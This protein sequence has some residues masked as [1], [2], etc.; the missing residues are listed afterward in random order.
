MKIRS[1]QTPLQN[2][3][4]N[5]LT[6]P[7]SALLTL[8]A[9]SLLSGCTAYNESFDCPAGKGIGCQSVTEVKKKLDQGGIN[10][11]ESTTQAYAKRNSNAF[12]PPIVMPIPVGLE[13]DSRISERSGGG[14][15]SSSGVVDKNLMIQRTA[16]KPLR[17]WIAPYQD[18]EGN[19]HE[20]SVVH[21]VVR[22]GSWQIQPTYS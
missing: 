6:K 11:P 1:L 21:T 7:L 13:A 8:S 18:G 17:V 14:D 19:F 3:P 20:A 16:E 12:L 4:E 15:L 10:I 2:R 22:P 9:I 5:H